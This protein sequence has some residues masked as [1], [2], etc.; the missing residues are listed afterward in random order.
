VKTAAV[1]GGGIAG[2]SA[3][4]ALAE[5]GF[6]V[7]LIER[8]AALATEASGNPL[9]VL[10]PRLTGQSTALELLN[11]HGYLHTL[12]LLNRLGLT[13]CQFQACGVIQ[14]AHDAKSQARLPVAV[15]AYAEQEHFQYMDAEQ[16][17]GIAGVSLQHAGLFFPAAGGISLATLCDVLVDDP[18]ITVLHS[19]AA[20]EISQPDPQ[21]PQWQVCTANTTLHADVVVIANANDACRLKQSAYMPLAAIRGQLSY[22]K[23]TA[24][25][26]PLNTIVC[27]EGYITPAFEDLHF[28]GASFNQHDDDA[29]LRPADHEGNLQLL[30]SI[31]PELHHTLKDNIV[32]GRVAWRSQ[33]PD[34]LPIAGQLL[35]VEALAGQKLFYNDA[36]SKLPWLPSLYISAGHG[37]KGFLSAPL[38]GHVIAR[39]AAGL[40]SELPP[41]LLNALQPNRFILRKLGLKQ[42]AQHLVNE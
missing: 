3:A 26:E 29:S 40:A 17:S 13:R 30:A 25:S 1:I 14:L 19:N 41:T 15:Q 38:C 37:S 12:A 20:L 8:H 27:A 5:H 11:L 18:S 39:H 21:N 22:L 33:T 23:K 6:A 16:L 10:N 34:Y 35:D 24:T 7:T 2:C 4:Y 31:S 28:L 42:L 9:A 32:S 36:P